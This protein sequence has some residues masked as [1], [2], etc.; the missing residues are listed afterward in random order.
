MSMNTKNSKEIKVIDIKDGDTIQFNYPNGY[1][2]TITFKTYGCKAQTISLER[3]ND[4]EPL[5]ISFNKEKEIVSFYDKNQQSIVKM[6]KNGKVTYR[7]SSVGD[8]VESKFE[9]DERNNIIHYNSSDGAEEWFEYDEN[10][11]MTK[12]KSNTGE[13]HVYKYDENNN[14]TESTLFNCNDVMIYQEKSEYDGKG[15]LIH[16]KSI[17]NVE[18][19]PCIVEW[20]YEYNE[21]GKMVHSKSINDKAET[22][23]E[24][25]YKYNENGKMISHIEKDEGKVIREDYYEYDEDGNQ[26]KLRR[27]ENGVERIFKYNNNEGEN[28]YE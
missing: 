18:E 10:N 9:Y 7:I 6:N 16:Q 17:N 3:D 14:C 8:N 15:Q 27:I 19:N 5:F 25:D 24:N 13:K 22:I 20:Y 21:N 28:D 26:C 4:Y 1:K 11:N 2:D 23:Y 12:C